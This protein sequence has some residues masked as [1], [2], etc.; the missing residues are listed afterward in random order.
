MKDS[1]IAGKDKANTTAP[2]QGQLGE[3]H[4]KGV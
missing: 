2:S 4:T 3:E 1:F